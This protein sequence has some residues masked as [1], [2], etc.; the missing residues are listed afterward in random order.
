MYSSIIKELPTFQKVLSD[1]N[2]FYEFAPE[3]LKN[4]VS[5]L[6]KQL[7]KHA[8]GSASQIKPDVEELKND[9]MK[10]RH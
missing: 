3:Q 10:S 1:N 7:K 8:A 5:A 6:F 4:T 9:I 2:V